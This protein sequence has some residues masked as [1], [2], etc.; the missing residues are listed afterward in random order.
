MT[1]FIPAPGA[2]QPTLAGLIETVSGL[3]GQETTALLG[4]G[5]VAVILAGF[6]VVS[7]LADLMTW[8]G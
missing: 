8:R 2:D 1:M 7:R 6:A 3:G 4:L 5:G